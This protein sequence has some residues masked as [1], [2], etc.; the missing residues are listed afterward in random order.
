M[1]NKLLFSFGIS[2]VALLIMS[3]QQ[4]G[5]TK[6]LNQALPIRTYAALRDSANSMDVTLYLGKG[7]SLSL[8]GKDVRLFGSFFENK[9]AVKTS[10][11]QAGMAM[12]LIDG[13]ELIT[14]NFYVG[15][16][17]GFIVFKKDGKEYVN[18]I[19][20]QGNSFFKR[21]MGLQ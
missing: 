7:G 21:Q 13:R 5:T 6:Q 19:S 17:T 1:K 12:W 4:Q 3:A 15:D 8:S 10:A 20:N 9:T 14:G 2:I 18:S 16:S 11:P